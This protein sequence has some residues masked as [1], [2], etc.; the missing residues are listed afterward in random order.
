MPFP[1]PAIDSDQVPEVEPVVLDF[2]NQ[3]VGFI[4]EQPTAGP[5]ASASKSASRALFFEVLSWFIIFA[6]NTS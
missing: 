4:D 5:N 6:F 3:L 1:A 2:E